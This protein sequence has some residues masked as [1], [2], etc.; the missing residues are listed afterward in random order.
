MKKYSTQTSEIIK[1]DPEIPW[2]LKTG[3]LP[4]IDI[5][6]T[7]TQM[8]LLNMCATFYFHSINVFVQFVKIGHLFLLVIHL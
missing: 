6:F 5:L 3:N 7:R 8:V 1:K 2:E 4:H